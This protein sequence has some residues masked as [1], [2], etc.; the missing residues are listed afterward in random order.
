MPSVP[1]IFTFKTVVIE[2]ASIEIGPVSSFKPGL[3]VSVISLVAIMSVP[4]RIGIIGISRVRIFKVYTDVDL[5]GSRIDGKTSG[6]DQ[7][8]NK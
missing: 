7:T 6:Y 3:I 2:A 1:M 8:K 5:G 4:C